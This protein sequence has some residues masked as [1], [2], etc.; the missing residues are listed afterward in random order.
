VDI[1]KNQKH[2]FFLYFDLTDLMDVLD[3]YQA[4][5]DWRIKIKQIEDKKMKTYNDQNTEN[6]TESQLDDL[7][8]LFD[9]Q[10][11]E[12]DT[13]DDNQVQSLKE[14]ILRDYDCENY[15][16]IP[17]SND[18]ANATDLNDLYRRLLK[19]QESELSDCYLMVQDAKNVRTDNL[20]TFGG[21]EPADTY[22]VFSWDK[23]NILTI[24]DDGKWILADRSEL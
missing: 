14:K 5:R 21:E 24:N 3:L 13:D 4:S 16:R 22:A 6:Y 23:D 11:A 15:S 12:I 9:E 8:R 1:K 2:E 19:I 7:N 17:D 18:P 10:S 20:P